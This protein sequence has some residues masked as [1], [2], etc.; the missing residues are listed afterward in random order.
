MTFVRTRCDYATWSRNIEHHRK[1]GLACAT[2]SCIARVFRFTGEGMMRVLLAAVALGA[3]VCLSAPSLA[4][5]VRAV[6]GDVRVNTGQG[7]RLVQ[8]GATANPGAIV[9]A[10]SGGRAQVVYPDGC[11]VPVG[12]GDPP[13]VLIHT[14]LRESPCKTRGAAYTRSGLTG[15]GLAGSGLTGIAVPALLLGGATAGVIALTQNKDDK[16]ASP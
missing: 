3:T 2:K 12:R 16:P 10:Q 11:V 14:V 5:T 15:S 6:Q 13:G 1:L 7:Y 4:A 9:A 8:S